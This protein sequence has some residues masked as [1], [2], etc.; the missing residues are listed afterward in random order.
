MLARWQGR[1]KVLARA[2][3]CVC[4]CVVTGGEGWE[5]IVGGRVERF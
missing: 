3:A 2:V 1:L 5:D 4:V